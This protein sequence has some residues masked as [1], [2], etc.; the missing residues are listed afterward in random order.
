MENQEN[1]IIAPITSH[2]R[3]AY[4]LGDKMPKP[5]R[6]IYYVLLA[7]TLVYWAY[8]LI[9]LT[10]DLIQKIGLFI[11][12][13]RN[14][15]TFVICLIILGV[16]ILLASQFIFDLDPFGKLVNWIVNKWNDFRAWCVKIIG[17]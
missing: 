7:I 13:K 3:L 9:A 2:K 16:G 6:V 14:Y 17:G 10:L 4:R 5:I 15:Y 1:V 12:E 8:R 11:F